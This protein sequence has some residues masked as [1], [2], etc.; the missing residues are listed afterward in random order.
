MR[1]VF[2]AAS[3]KVQ[4]LSLQEVNEDLKMN[5]KLT[6]NLNVQSELRELSVF[7]FFSMK[8]RVQIR[9]LK[10][11][12]VVLSSLWTDMPVGFIVCSPAS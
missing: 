8:L 10:L 6:K 1:T 5:N 4:S 11:L 12:A 9:Y 2:F 3:L 7:F